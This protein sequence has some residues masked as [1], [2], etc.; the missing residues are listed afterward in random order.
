MTEPDQLIDD[1]IRQ[2]T[3]RRNGLAVFG[4]VDLTRTALLVL[5]MQNAWL[6]DGAPFRVGPPELFEGLLDRINVFAQSVRAGHGQVIWIRTTVGA[7]GSPD[8]WNTYYDNFI[9]PVKRAVAVAALTPGSPMHPLHADADVQAGDWVLDKYRFNAFAR[10]HHDLEARLRAQGIDSVMVA[11]TATNICCES[12][13]REA[14]TRDFRTFMP[15]DLV[16]APTRDGHAAGLRNVMQAF[17]DVRATRDLDYRN[18]RSM[19]T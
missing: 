11:G 5:N 15:H 12:T 10:N 9:E 6:A 16:A 18:G 3:Y 2:A 7:V 13:I 14:M 17:A 8:Y 19:R 1:L 4:D